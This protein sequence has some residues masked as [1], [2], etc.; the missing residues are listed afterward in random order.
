M[1]RSAPVRSEPILSTQE[2]CGE[3]RGVRTWLVERGVA[4]T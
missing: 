2:R 4:F 1:G 3:S